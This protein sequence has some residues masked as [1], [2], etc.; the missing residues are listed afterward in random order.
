MDTSSIG[1]ARGFCS[2]GGRWP[3]PRLLLSTLW[4]LGAMACGT[5][6]LAAEPGAPAERHQSLNFANGLSA[7]GLSANGLSANGLSANGL[8]AN[9]LSSESFRA[10]FT[11]AP[12]H[13]DMVMQY[14]VRCAVPEGQTRTYTPPSSTQTYTWQGGLG[15]TP[16][17]AGGQPISLAEQQ[18]LTACLAAHVNKYGVSILI[19]VLGKT[20]TGQSIPYTA[21]EIQDYAIQEGCFFGNIFTGQGIF[22]GNDSHLLK[23]K[24]TSARACVLSSDHPESMNACSPMVYTGPCEQLC[25]REPHA[26]FYTACT[27][28]GVTYR[29]I[30][31]RIH[32]DDVYKCGDGVCQ[33]TES[34]GQGTTANSCEKDC[35]RCP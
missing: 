25:T 16:G 33:F 11:H 29:P 12:A 5:E 8:S 20:A 24:E 31:T 19:S 18:L 4:L 7:N 32:P 22:Y 27:W 23:D 3:Q 30:T 6:E 35:G 1:D 13:A 9:G 2:N 17:W 34:C 15:L 26:P 10:W 28:K 21:T 14:V